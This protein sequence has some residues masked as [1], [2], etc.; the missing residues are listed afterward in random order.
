MKQAS[1][2]ICNQKGG[3]GKSTFTMLLASWKIQCKLPPKTKVI[4]PP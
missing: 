2:S 1:I 4:L 3:I